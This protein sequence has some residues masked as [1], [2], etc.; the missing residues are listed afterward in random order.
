[1]GALAGRSGAGIFADT[2]LQKRQATA[3]SPACAAYAQPELP[4][5]NSP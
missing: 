1:L 4:A 5:R 3:Y 2:G